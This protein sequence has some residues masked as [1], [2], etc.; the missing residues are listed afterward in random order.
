MGAQLLLSDA[1]PA[2][3]DTVHTEIR[4]RDESVILSRGF[5]SSI[6]FIG[7]ERKEHLQDG[8]N[9][10]EKNQQLNHRTDFLAAILVYRIGLLTDDRGPLRYLVSA[11]PTPPAFRC[12]SSFDCCLPNSSRS[13]CVRRVPHVVFQNVTHATGIC[14]SSTAS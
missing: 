14:Q 3:T 2:V 10:N 13:A 8:K 1:R 4:E 5:C 11:H 6:R 7:F 9:N 12:S